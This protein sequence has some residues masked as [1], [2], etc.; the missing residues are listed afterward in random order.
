MKITI[1]AARVNIGLTQG[2]A[3]KELGISRSTLASYESGKTKPDI[4]MAGKIALLY[5]TS[6]DALIF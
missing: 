1:K 3:A 2:K 4:D 6:V 5:K